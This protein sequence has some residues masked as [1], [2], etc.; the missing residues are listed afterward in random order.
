MSFA[1]ALEPVFRSHRSYSGAGVG[2]NSDGCGA[3]EEVVGTCEPRE[4][5]EFRAGGDTRE[6]RDLFDM[7]KLVDSMIRSL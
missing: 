7:T 1:S 4:P 5:L 2:D 6:L 3:H